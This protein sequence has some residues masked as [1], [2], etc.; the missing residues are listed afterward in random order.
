MYQPQRKITAIKIWIWRQILSEIKSSRRRR[1]F[2]KFGQESDQSNPVNACHVGRICLEIEKKQNTWVCEVEE[3]GSFQLFTCWTL[4]DP[5]GE[6][7]EREGKESLNIR[8][9]RRERWGYLYC[10]H[11]LV[12]ILER[13]RERESWVG[14]IFREELL[15][16]L[17]GN[18]SFLL[19]FIFFFN[20]YF[21]IL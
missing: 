21:L 10:F 8:L 15:S 16:I 7:R 14:E 18:H 12:S 6:E 19:S 5:T 13:E 1:I 9:G 2:K 11:F 20:D 17:S 4:V 3:R